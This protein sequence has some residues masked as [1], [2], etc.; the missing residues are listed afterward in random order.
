MYVVLRLTT[1]VTTAA[2]RTF[3]AKLSVAGCQN[4]LH[5]IPCNTVPSIHLSPAGPAPVCRSVPLRTRTQHVASREST[6]HLS[7]GFA[8]R[9]CQPTVEMD[10]GATSTIRAF[11]FSL[12]STLNVDAG[13]RVKGQG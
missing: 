9:R 2:Q 5:A 8:D 3:S 10:L 13:A 6:E 4:N 7:S 1:V 11:P 12:P